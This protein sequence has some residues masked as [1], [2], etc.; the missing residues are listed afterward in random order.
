MKLPPVA[1]LPAVAVGGDAGAAGDF[2][3]FLWARPCGAGGRL[4]GGVPQERSIVSAI[5]N[6]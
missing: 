2:T 1:G 3:E 6:R 4:A 5:L